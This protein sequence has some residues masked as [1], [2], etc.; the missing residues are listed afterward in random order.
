MWHA[1]GLMKKAG[2]SIL[3]KEEGNKSSIAKAFKMHNNYDYVF[4]SSAT[5]EDAISKV[6]G[7]RTN[8][9]IPMPLPRVDCLTDD[10][11]IQRARKKIHKKYPH[12]TKKKNIV[13]VPTFRADEEG[14][15]EKINQL[16]GLIDYNKYN[17]IIKL[18]SLSKSSVNNK[19]VF[20]D[21]FSSMEKLCIS[22]YVI[23]DYSAIIYEAAILQKPLFLYA[24]DK[25]EYLEK[26]ELFIDYDEE[27]PC[28]ISNNPNE[29]YNAIESKIYNT[30][31]MVE[32][33][34]KYVCLDSKTNTYN[35]VKFIQEC[36]KDKKHAIRVPEK[37][38][39]STQIGV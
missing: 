32:F 23:S 26:R 22:D 30:E 35:I 9:I 28:V 31:E 34:N 16:A 29:I 6:F 2:Y 25:E 14:M 1:V 24:F 20:V 39:E 11:Y 4:S 3:D 19:N 17:L 8:K 38:L 37:E 13:Y 18:H 21:E 15:M 7:C 12:L 36:L 10:K 27:I 33:A 5:C